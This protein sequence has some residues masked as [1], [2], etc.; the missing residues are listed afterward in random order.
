M[1][2]SIDKYR[3]DAPF[4]A[5]LKRMTVNA[6]IDQLR[7][8]RH[9]ADGDPEALFAQTA[10]GATDATPR[11]DA[12]TLLGHLPPRARAIVALHE[13]EGYT[14][15]EL[16]QLFGQSESYSKSIVSRA[17]K[18]LHALVEPNPSAA[19]ERVCA[20]RN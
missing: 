14:H 2:D 8:L 10:S 17:L 6:C 7:R 19:T 9:R 12:W 5:W 15:A 4:G 11:L 13:L 20:S 3:G 18:R 1:I 16:A